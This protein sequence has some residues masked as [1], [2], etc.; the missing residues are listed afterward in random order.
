MPGQCATVA[1]NGPAYLPPPGTEGP[2]YLG[3]VVDPRNYK[4]EL[5]DDNNRNPCSRMG[6][7]NMADF[8][9]KS[10]TDP[11]SSP[12][13]RSSELQVQVCNQGTM[14]DSTD[15]EVYLSADAIITPHAAEP[16]PV[17]YVVCAAVP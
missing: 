15:V 4:V 12:T 9:V 3:A 2:Y 17:W 13:R 8:V 11:P 7:G 10:V 16:S 6:V 5:I 1:V 14:A